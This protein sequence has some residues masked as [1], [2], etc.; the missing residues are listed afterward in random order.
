MVI[1]GAL[2]VVYSG[3]LAFVMFISFGLFFARLI[4][5]TKRG[6]TDFTIRSEL[7]F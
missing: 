5:A 4:N 3:M 2:V 1:L 6:S 7:R